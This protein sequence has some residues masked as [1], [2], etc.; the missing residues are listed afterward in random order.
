[1]KI[2]VKP[3]YH[4]GDQVV[5]IKFLLWPRRVGNTIIWLEKAKIVYTFNAYIPELGAES[6]W[7]ETIVPLVIT[8]K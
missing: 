8:K 5:K 7:Q 4:D 2:T 1:M 3:K 6:F